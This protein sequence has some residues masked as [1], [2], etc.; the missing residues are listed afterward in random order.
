MAQWQECKY[1]CGQRWLP[2]KY[3]PTNSKHERL[4]SNNPSRVIRTV[5]ESRVS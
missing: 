1:N 3:R 4:C 5:V 2:R